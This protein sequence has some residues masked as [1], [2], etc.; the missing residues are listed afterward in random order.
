MNTHAASTLWPWPFDLWV[1]ACRGCAIEYMFTKF[2]VDSSSRFPFTARTDIHTVTDA[3]DHPT[4]HWLWMA[5][6]TTELLA[7]TLA[8]ISLTDTC[9]TNTNITSACKVFN[10]P[11]RREWLKVYITKMW[12][13]DT[14]ACQHNR[15]RA[16]KHNNV[17][18]STSVQ[19]WVVFVGE[20]FNCSHAL[21]TAATAFR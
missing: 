18:A 14:S 20:Q 10:I 3:T 6:V 11:T 5:W 7:E 21:L 15:F 12:H 1:N 9:L 16:I 17:F 2:G 13:R 8:S 4:M 19:K